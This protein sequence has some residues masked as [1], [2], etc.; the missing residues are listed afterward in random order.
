MRE[1]GGREVWVHVLAMRS[2]ALGIVECEG[3]VMCVYVYMYR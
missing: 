2:L 3:L 1:R